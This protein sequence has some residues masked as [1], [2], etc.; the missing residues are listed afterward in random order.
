MLIKKK[1]S[2]FLLLFL[3]IYSFGQTIKIKEDRV[4][5]V[6]SFSNEKITMQLDY[7]D[8]AN[9]YSLTINNQNLIESNAGIYSE[10][11]TISTTYSSLKLLSKPILHIVG[12]TI[13]LSNIVYG[14]A[15]VSINETW[16]FIVT[17]KDIRFDIDRTISKPIQAEQIASP[18]FMF[19]HIND[20]EGAYQDYGGLAWFY[21][22]NTKLDTYGVHSST[23]AFWNSVTNNGLNISA[24][25]AGKK[26]AMSYSR[27][28]DDKLAYRIVESEKEMPLRFDSGT[29][30]RRYV[31]DT[32]AVWAPITMHAGKSSQSIQLSYFDF[33]E[34][35][36]RGNFVG[37]NGDEVSAVLNTIAHIGVI[38]KQHFGGNSWHTPYGPICLHEQYIAQMGLGI[39][40]E[41]YLKGYQDCLDY[42]RD[43]AIKPDG[44]VWPRWAYSN[45][46]AMP[47]IFTDKG[48]YEAQWGY[49][50][51]ANPDFVTN[52]SELYD[53]TGN[54]VWVKGQQQACEKALDWIL[55]RD[56]NNNGLVEMIPDNHSEGKSSDWIDI[57]W[58][59]YENALVNAKLY[60]ALLLWSDIE[61]QLGNKAK[62]DYYTGFAKKMK[63]SFNKPVSDGGFWDADHQCYIHWRDKDGSI[64]G[65]NMVTPINLMAISYGICEDE[66]RKK[67]ILDAIEE[68]MQKEHL[69]FWPICL[70]SYKEGEGKNWQFPFPNYENGD[71]FL[72]WGALGVNAY[73]SYK[74]ELALKYVM[75]V[76]AQYAKDGLAYQRY[77]RAKQDGLGDDILSGNS[78]SVVGLYQAI[79]GINPLYNRFYLNPHITAELAGTKINYN[80]RGQKLQIG[81]DL[82]KY[83]VSNGLFSIESDH[84]FGFYATGHSLFYFNGKNENASL[85]ANTENNNLHLDIKNWDNDKIAWSQSSAIT[86][87]SKII[88]RLS[89][90]KPNTV[91]YITINNKIIEHK[92]T[93]AGGSLL[94][95][96]T[97]G[98]GSDEILISTQKT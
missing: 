75:N 78:L 14:D 96:C 15:H 43:N 95:N 34:R 55:K 20:W 59:S 60:H 63:T 73:A 93:D 21:L 8:K 5:Q 1:I 66:N 84:D 7:R 31:R 81:L 77:G 87:P 61:K 53:Q 71:L 30:R 11:K 74:P 97:T 37:V 22:F 13:T 19:N 88:Y 62:A 33:K 32:M 25:S 27:T 46:D 54:K 4:N 86:K 35:Y 70:Y 28:K 94:F 52:V 51:D 41:A 36:G 45:E 48:F 29:N 24:S 3:S 49:L 58:A 2:L 39:N 72:S 65:T 38:D 23:S 92:K 69:F 67:M 40:D 76:L 91:Y 18:V 90:L 26:I 80:F 17:E 6:V 9:I 44:S 10:I 64:H 50:L 79:Y 47:G 56:G 68:Q 42:Y 89:Q 98:K 83:S 57:I 12:N 82:N 85:K 16:K